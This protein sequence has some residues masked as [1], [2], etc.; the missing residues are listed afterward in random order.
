LSVEDGLRRIEALY[1][2]YHRALRQLI[3]HVYDAFRTAILVDCHSMPSVGISRDEIA[4][5]RLRDRRSLR[6]QLLTSVDH[7]VEDALMSMR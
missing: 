2:P 1:K 5:A 7:V 4:P 3:G 6:H